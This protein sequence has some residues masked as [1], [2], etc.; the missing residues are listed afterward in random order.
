MLAAGLLAHVLVAGGAIAALPPA[1]KL[2]VSATVS[3]GSGVSF[4]GVG[5]T[6]FARRSPAFVMVDVGFIHP[7]LTWLEFAP[8][9][10]LEVEG[11]VGFGVMPK[12]RA[13]VP[14][15]GRRGKPSRILAYGSLGV[16]AYIA[17][18]TLVGVQVGIGLGVQL[19]EHF[20]VVVEGTGA[21][22]FLGSD[23]MDGTA[24]GKADVNAGLR[25]RF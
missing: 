23:R 25:V 21:G 9:L 17:P 7:Q 16:P 10:M 14:F 13:F 12:L 18:Y 8:T 2:Q 20:A 22:Y 4:A 1:E 3:A 5:G 15:R 6:T 11:R 24:L 19:L